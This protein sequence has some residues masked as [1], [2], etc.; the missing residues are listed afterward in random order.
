MLKKLLE[1]RAAALTRCNELRELSLTRELTEEERTESN[2]KLAEV[3]SL[4]TQIGEQEELDRATTEQAAA[5]AR[6][7]ATPA[8]PSRHQKQQERGAPGAAGQIVL[9]RDGEDAPW[10]SPG[11]FFQ[12]IRVTAES[13]GAN[14]DPRLNRHD[15]RRT[16]VRAAAGLNETAGTEGGFLVGQ[17]VYTDLMKA[18]FESGAIAGR[19]RKI[20]VSSTSNSI[21]INGIE[22]TS[23][24]TG[25]RWGGVQVYWADEADSFTGSQPKFSK[26]ELHLSKLLGLCY[27]TEELLQDGVALSSVLNQAFAEEFSFKLDD[28][29]MRGTG[30][31]QLQGILNASAK[32]AVAKEGSQA[33]ATILYA[34]VSKMRARMMP[35]SFQNAVWFVNIDTSTQLEQ[36]FIPHKNVAGTENVSGQSVYMPPGGATAQPFGTLF[37]RP[38]IPVEQ[39]E[40]LGT[41]GDIVLADL[42]MYLMATKGG[43]QSA[44]SIHVQFLTDQIAYRFVLRTAG[45]PALKSAIT[46]YKGSGTLSPFVTLASRS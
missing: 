21:R 42:G 26:I 6:A 15:V 16:E 9:T 23:R 13:R 46:P 28:G 39:C 27:V 37:G 38:V 33:A 41:E 7:A 17:D 44:S 18:A 3:R 36:M 10:A 32:I 11:E 19:T 8:E 34:N 24:A 25:S 1:K 20:P 22:E 43:V 4:S 40:T 30:V 12:A 5:E 14:M 45:Q 29:V 31:G 35:R 2:A